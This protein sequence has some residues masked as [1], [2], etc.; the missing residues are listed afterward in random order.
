MT[1]LYIQLFAHFIFPGLIF[2]IYFTGKTEKPE[3]RKIQFLKN[4]KK[5]YI[6]D[7]AN[8]LHLTYFML[9]QKITK[10]IVLKNRDKIQNLLLSNN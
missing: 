10:F 4:G 5:Y 1:N 3:K 6:L 9:K 8:V 2:T 7:I